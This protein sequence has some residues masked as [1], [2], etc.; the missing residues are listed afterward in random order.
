[1]PQFR[2]CWFFAPFR[3]EITVVKLIHFERDPTAE[4]HAV[5]D[6]ADGHFILRQA[7][8]DAIPHAAAHGAVKFADGITKGSKAQRQNGHTEIFAIV[9]GIAAT[10]G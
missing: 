6:V 1:L 5:G 3:T 4:M 2:V 8:P 10:Q 9:R 7:G